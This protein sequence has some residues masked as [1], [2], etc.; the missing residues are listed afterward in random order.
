M[1]SW[2]NSAKSHIREFRNKDCNSTSV[3]LMQSSEDSSIAS[4]HNHRLISLSLDRCVGRRRWASGRGHTWVDRSFNNFARLTE[5]YFSKFISPPW[6]SRLVPDGAAS[7]FDKREAPACAPVGRCVNQWP[8]YDDPSVQNSSACQSI[9]VMPSSS[10][11]SAAL[12]TVLCPGVR[13]IPAQELKAREAAHAKGG[14]KKG[15]RA[16]A[17]S[18]DGSI[19]NGLGEN[20]QLLERDL[21]YLE[22][23]YRE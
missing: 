19:G 4:T 12:R 8:R 18:D 10:S 1:R 21:A 13:E 3:A 7:R 9:P 5:G 20:V 22:A 14:A 2:D 23:E 6:R 11:S 17:S 15:A 16:R